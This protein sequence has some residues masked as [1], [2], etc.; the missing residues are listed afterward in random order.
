VVAPS[1]R[2]LVS[3]L[4]DTG[5]LRR[6]EREVDPSWEPACLAKWMFQ[7]FPDASRFG[8]LFEQVKGSRI[9]LAFGVIGASRQHYARAIGGAAN[10]INPRIVAA[11][12][13]PVAPVVVERAVVHD[14][15][16]EGDNADIGL[17]P[18]PVWTPGKDIG[19]YITA[20]VTTRNA[21]SSSQNIGIYR[22]QVSGPRDLTVNLSPGRQ[23]TANV[24]SFTERALPAPIAWIIGPDPAVTV[25]SVANLPPGRSEFEFAGGLGSAP[26][27]LVRARTV[28][29]LVPANAEIVIEAII[30]P[31]RTGLEGPFG[32]FAGY[33][34]PTGP[35]PIARVTA[36]THRS[37]PVYH[38][39]SSQMPPSESTI[40]QGLTN[41]GY[42]LK[43][44][45]DDIGESSVRD[46]VIDET[47]GGL[48]GH[49]IVAMKTRYPAHGKKIGRI[50]ADISPLKRVTVVDTD[51][52]IRD[53]SH[54]DW[55]LNV[56][57]NPVR[58]AVIID[59]VQFG[60][61]DPSVEHLNGRPQRG[62]KIVIDATEKTSLGTYSLP[63]KDYMDRALEIWRELELPEFEISRRMILNLERP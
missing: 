42:L 53:P 57:F 47:F 38:A 55:A 63:S 54:V 39:F 56:R 3:S 48:L 41:A 15:V 62:S 24:A 35:R 31:D 21:Q 30:E 45:Q 11:L 14:V 18:V 17:L 29:L 5:S 7:N 26:V 33:M 22:T 13:S 40:L 61:I 43:V 25:A 36:I 52:D 19:P 49:A 9:P 32:E 27:E 6:I 28:D 8:F 46:I 2:A 20:T 50:I 34:G 58:D 1:L 37:N 59:D 4:I 16:L 12:R 60:N 23:G 51:I 10:E 44:L